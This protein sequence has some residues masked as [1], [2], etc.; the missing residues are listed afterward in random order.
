MWW[1][2]MFD[3]GIFCHLLRLMGI[4]R[5]GAPVRVGLFEK[6]RSH[7]SSVS[8]SFSFLFFNFF[9]PLLSGAPLAPGP[10]DIVHPCHPVATPLMP[11]CL[12]VALAWGHLSW[13]LVIR[14]QRE[15][16][17]WISGI[18]EGVWNCSQEM[19]IKLYRLFSYCIDYRRSGRVTEF[20]DPN[21]QQLNMVVAMRVYS[22]SA[23]G[24]LH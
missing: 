1:L 16:W 7:F 3:F 10:L 9:F 20:A 8:F 11:C 18:T 23:G 14:Y 17:E 19:P 12:Y 2:R 24:T 5:V 13:D 15:K 4:Y 6:F 22:I 21:T